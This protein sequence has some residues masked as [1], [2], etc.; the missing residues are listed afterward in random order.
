VSFEIRPTEPFW[1]HFREKLQISDQES[2]LDLIEAMREHPGEFIDRK[3]N[4]PRRTAVTRVIPVG[5]GPEALRVIMFFQY[6][7][8][9]STIHLYDLVVVPPDS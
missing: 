8:D 9:E 2:V 6:D 4:L 3:S 5:T 1:K 7:S